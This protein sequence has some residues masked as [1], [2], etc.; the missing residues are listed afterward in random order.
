MTSEVEIPAI[1]ED[2]DGKISAEEIELLVRDTMAELAQVRLHDL[3]E[4][5][6]QGFHPTKAPDF[7]ARIDDPA[8]FTPPDWDRSE[9][10]RQWPRPSRPPDLESPAELGQPG[11]WLDGVWGTL[12]AR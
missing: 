8:T 5:R 12:T 9:G 1:D 2:K 6:R 4:H 11:D 7:T 10:H 3:A